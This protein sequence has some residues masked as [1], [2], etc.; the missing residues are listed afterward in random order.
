MANTPY[1]KLAV[2]LIFSWFLLSLLGSARKVYRN[3]SDL[4]ALSLALAAMGPSRVRAAE[5]L[6]RGQSRLEAQLS[7]ST[8]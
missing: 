8:V 2:G 1:R 3:N 4:P 6:F 5:F 7:S